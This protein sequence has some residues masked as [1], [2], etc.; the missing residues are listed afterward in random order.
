MNSL[1]TFH[2]WRDEKSFGPFTP[3]Q[4]RE[5]LRVGQIKSSTLVAPVGSDEWIPLTTF[6]EILPA[7]EPA[8]KPAAAP[9]PAPAPDGSGALKMGQTRFALGVIA[10]ALIV[11]GLVWW[12]NE[13]S[14]ANQRGEVELLQEIDHGLSCINQYYRDKSDGKPDAGHWLSGNFAYFWL[15]KYSNHPLA[16]LIREASAAMDAKKAGDAERLLRDLQR[17]LGGR[18]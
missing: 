6:P 18:R 3:G 17:H 1:Q 9:P 2:V 5:M 10:A 13:R 15:Q 4:L 7:S 12:Q 16:P 11:A 14:A 8:E